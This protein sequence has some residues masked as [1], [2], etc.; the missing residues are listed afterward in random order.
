[1]DIIVV[2]SKDKKVDENLHNLY[3][4]IVYEETIGTISN[5]IMNYVNN[6]FDYYYI[7]N[8]IIHARESSIDTII[9]GSSYGRFRVNEEDIP[10]A[11][12]LSLPSQDIYYS[13]KSIKKVCEFNDG[14]K[15]IV[16][17]CGYYYFFCDLS[18]S[19]NISDFYNILKVYVPLFGDDAYHN[20]NILVSKNGGQRIRQSYI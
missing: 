14:I 16:L 17:C 15:N 10:H 2:S 8:S 4:V 9:T 12:N 18:K 19:K 13:L 7:K 3:N 20:C 5:W 6:Y 11:V 1:M